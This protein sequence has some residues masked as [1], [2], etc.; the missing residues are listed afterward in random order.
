MYVEKKLVLVLIA[1]AVVVLGALGW[2]VVSLEAT[3]KAAQ[4]AAAQATTS[5]KHCQACGAVLTRAALE[6][7]LTPLRTELGGI[8]T[9]ARGARDEAI[10][11]RSGM[12]QIDPLTH[13]LR[14]SSA[15]A[16][17]LL[18]ALARNGRVDVGAARADVEKMFEAHGGKPGGWFW[19]PL[20]TR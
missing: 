11:I 3:A 5:A 15:Y 6:E 12:P 10:A 19:G 20:P 2:T 17:M 9:E 8:L 16:E 14:F 7:A 1:A 4:D 18:E 13:F